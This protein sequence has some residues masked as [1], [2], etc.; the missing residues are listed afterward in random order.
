MRWNVVAVSTLVGPGW[1]RDVWSR[2]VRGLG[3]GHVE[4]TRASPRKAEAGTWML[5]RTTRVGEGSWRKVE[6][7]VGF[8]L[9]V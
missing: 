1:F 4:G 2:L 3:E 7:S 5:R 6:F 9:R 8:C